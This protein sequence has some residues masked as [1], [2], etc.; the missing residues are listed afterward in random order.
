MKI[1]YI[2][3]A[4]EVFNWGAEGMM[5]YTTHGSKIFKSSVAGIKYVI[6]NTGSYSGEV[7]NR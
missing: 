7:Q 5:C 4:R 6:Y 3:S 2:S 1:G